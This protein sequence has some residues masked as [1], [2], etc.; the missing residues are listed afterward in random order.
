MAA[1]AGAGA[2]GL[3]GGLAGALIGMGIS[4]YEAKRYE[5]YYSG[6]LQSSEHLGSDPCRGKHRAYASL[7]RYDL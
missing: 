6:R 4:E 3:A 2:G 1:L 5:G 7:Q